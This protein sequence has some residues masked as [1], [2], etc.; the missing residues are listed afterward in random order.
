MANI[1]S[2][3]GVKSMKRYLEKSN[4]CYLSAKV[5]PN[6]ETL[7]AE[8]SKAKMSVRSGRSR[9]G[10]PSRKGDTVQKETAAE[11]GGQIVLAVELNDADQKVEITA[12]IC[13]EFRSLLCIYE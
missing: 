13:R 11:V 4:C 12:I 10:G 2:V 8:V 5:A 9:K 1:V 7:T 3:T 6:Q